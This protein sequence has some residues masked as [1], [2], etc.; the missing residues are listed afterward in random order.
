MKI[1][2]SEETCIGLVVLAGQDEVLTV[3]H[4]ESGKSDEISP[5]RTIV[6]A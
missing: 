3:F 1:L 4:M 5:K 2:G 6:H